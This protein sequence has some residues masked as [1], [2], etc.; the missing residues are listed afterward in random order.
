MKTI[1]LE[2]QY[3]KEVKLNRN[4]LDHLKKFKKIGLYSSIQFISHLPII[5]KQLEKMGIKTVSS[6]P[7]RAVQEGQLLG[8]DCFADS[9]NLKETVDA[10]LYIGDGQF[11]PLALIY[12][13]DKEVV[14]YNPISNSFEVLD[15]QRVQN[16]INKRKGALAKFYASTN[17]GV[18]ISVKP[19]Q[20]QL[21]A[22]LLLEKKYSEK[23]FYYFVDNNISFDQLENF[24]FVEVWVNTAC[25]RIGID[26]YEK[27]RKGVVNV[28]DLM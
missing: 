9:L 5:K 28:K 24:P 16:I 6:K 17:I 2:A 10:F 18:I 11:H 27:V 8:C 13:Q 25:P 12:G 21:K 22:A 4:I 15:K 3:N 26:D 23:H 19:G 7:R 1:F 14:C 20:E